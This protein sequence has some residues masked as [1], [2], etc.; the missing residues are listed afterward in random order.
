M[1]AARRSTHR[2]PATSAG[3]GPPQ[4]SR[5]AR[6]AASA[7]PRA[8]RTWRQPAGK[9]RACQ[10]L[11]LPRRFWPEHGFRRPRPQLRHPIFQEKFCP[12]PPVHKRRP[13]AHD[14]SAAR[15]ERPPARTLDRGVR[16]SSGPSIAARARLSGCPRPPIAQPTASSSN[17]A[18]R[19]A[20]SGSSASAAAYRAR[21]T[22]SPITVTRARPRTRPARPLPRSRS[23]DDHRH[24]GHRRHRTVTG[25]RGK[26]SR[27]TA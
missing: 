3:P 8:A 13:A 22:S 11:R 18:V 16:P 4:P 1:T 6:T 12:F 2:H 19:P 7:S 25:S 21:A 17:C 5:A 23:R 26:T 15:P 9:A 14:R 24:S 20:A 10:R 27:D